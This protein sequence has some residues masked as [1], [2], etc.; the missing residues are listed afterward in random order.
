MGSLKR[1]CKKLLTEA[2]STSLK[3]SQDDEP[4]EDSADSKLL[5]H[6]PAQANL[7]SIQ[8]DEDIDWDTFPLPDDGI[9]ERRYDKKSGKV[10]AKYVH[11]LFFF[12]PT[13]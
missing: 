9:W 13:I 7:Q 6:S 2:D 5:S 3:N 12:S 4:K 1:E 8:S 10:I 11:D